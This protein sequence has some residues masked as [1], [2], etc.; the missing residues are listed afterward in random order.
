MRRQ[1]MIVFLMSLTSTVGFWG[2]STWVPPFVGGLA[3]ASGL[4]ATEWASYAGMAYTF[5]SVVGYVSLGFLVDTT[6]IRYM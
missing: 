6:P 3:A 5:G 4:N 2:I 1:T